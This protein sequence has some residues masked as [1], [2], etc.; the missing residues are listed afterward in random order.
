MISELLLPQSMLITRL[1]ASF[2]TSFAVVLL[3]GNRFICYLHKW[4]G[5]GQPIRENGPQSHL[6][7]KKG[8]PTM[9]GLLL[10]S[11]IIVSSLLWCRLSNLFVWL[12]IA[13][14]LIYG[15]TG[16][17]D[18]YVKVKKQTP[19]AM[20]AKMKLILQFATALIV[21]TLIS[22]YTP[23]ASRFSLHVPYVDYCLNLWW[24]YIPFAMIVMTG[25]SNAVNLSD[26]LDGLASGLCISAFSAF[27]VVCAVVG[28]AGLST[29]YGIFIPG[30]EE[31]SVV[32]AA[33]V[34]ACLGFLWFNSSPAKVFMGDTGSLALGALLGTC[35]IMTKQEILLVIIGLVFVVETLS[36]MIQVF[37][38]KRTKRRVFLM[39]PIHHHFE[40]LGW[41]ET[42]IVARFRIISIICAAIGLS[43]F[44]F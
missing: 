9:G 37:W 27:V 2:L 29:E 17:I 13:V 23:S 25:S 40:Q 35:A 7:T 15:A 12:C 22:L 36:V 43:A 34:G 11:A 10:L 26:G 3:F 31:V 16:F 41:K 21:V 42:M 8:T 5:L 28:Q 32:C 14:I 19:D 38:Y 6:L 44:L 30:C 20:T 4:Q 24:F 1:L 33:T 39:A 18:D